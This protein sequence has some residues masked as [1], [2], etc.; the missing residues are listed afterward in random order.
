MRLREQVM[1]NTEAK[2]ATQHNAV[3]LY[4]RVSSERQA[5][6]KTIESQL[7]SLH[8]YA[9]EHSYKIE[10]KNVFVD[11]GIS[12][13]ELVR[14]G[15]E[16]LRDAV[17][18]HT[19]DCIVVLC[20]D[21]LA[22][23]QAHQLI[24]TEEFSRHDVDLEFVNHTFSSSPEDQL[25]LQMQGAIAEYEREKIMERTR[26]GK[27]F[28]AKNQQ[29]CVLSNAPYGFVYKKK[30][31]CGGIAAYELHPEE[32]KVVRSVYQMYGVEQIPMNA[33][34]QRLTAEGVLAPK[35]GSHWHRSSIF[36]MLTNPAY[37]GSA[38]YKKTQVIPRKIGALAKSAP[39][40]RY[41]KS[42][43]TRELI[44]R[45]DWI[46]IRVPHIVPD[47][48][49]ER[50]QEQILKNKQLSSRNNKRNQYLL[51][52]LLRCKE[53]GY[54]IHGITTLSRETYRSYY[55]CT[56]KQS[57]RFPGG[58]KCTS[59]YIPSAV[60]DDLAWN[61]TK[62][63][64][65]QPELVLAEYTK[66]I[67]Q[68]SKHKPQLEALIATKKK[69]IR[70]IAHEQARILDLYQAGT[71]NLNHIK[72]RIASIEQRLKSTNEEL[73][74]LVATSHAEH[75]ELRLIEQFQAFQD[76]FKNKI[77]QLSFDEKKKII[78]LLAR[79]V[80]VDCSTAQITLKHII[81]VGGNVYGLRSDRVVTSSVYTL[82]CPEESLSETA[83]SSSV[84]RPSWRCT[85]RDKMLLPIRTTIYLNN[86]LLNKFYLAK[87]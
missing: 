1:T 3:A 68:T 82:R 50:V 49:Y 8:A 45:E 9:K 10:E 64:I 27:V 4:A 81:P 39:M 34:A 32:S 28:K 59:H 15:L 5:E 67:Q 35:G 46:S 16:A 25:F 53:C 14:P 37:M 31:D 85:L 2:R 69:E 73:N 18:M 13:T 21:R 42:S 52:G 78:Q 7:A 30:S 83:D 57:W 20:P 56:G 22:R 76:K 29:V 11:N 77:D 48:L 71:I 44:K 55:V 70:Q 79:R 84:A 65:E 87:R 61:Q 47:S 75:Q 19:I 80:I 26:R 33:I 41:P 54:S 86:K 51:T 43:K 36:R 23:K 12:G 60:L 62:K 58:A 6:E 24:L 63:L 40:S 17:A 72:E 74:E 38:A 66:R